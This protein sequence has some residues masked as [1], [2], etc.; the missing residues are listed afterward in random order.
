MKFKTSASILRTSEI[1]NLPG[2]DLN[3][4]NINYSL[5]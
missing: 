2:D 5:N 1:V 4:K 3:D